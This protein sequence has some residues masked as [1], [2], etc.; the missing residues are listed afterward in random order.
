MA[1]AC[2][3]P[4]IKVAPEPPT[5]Y[6][7][8]TTGRGSACG[9]N[10]FGVIPLGVNDRAERA[11]DEALQASGGTGLTDVSVTERWYWIYVGDTFCTD[12]EGMGYT[13][14]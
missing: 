8:T 10:L 12:I 7:A 2:T 9:L 1:A 4:L 5:D 14:R 3:D 6:V 11:Y 13:R